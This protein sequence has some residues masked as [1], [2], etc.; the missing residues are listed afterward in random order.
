MPGTL[1]LD[2]EGLS[3]LYLKDRSVLALVQAA[4][5]EGIRVATSAM[6][7]L[8][9][10]YE[11]IHPA[12]ISWVLSRIDIH[13]VTRD[14]AAQAAALLRHHHLHGHKYAIDAVLAA[15]AHNAPG[16]VTVVTSDP[17]DLSQLCGPT[18]EIITA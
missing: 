10:D 13:D 1:L 8:E 6:T 14:L 7:T 5:E 2:S 12:R 17:E 3:K 4:T 9:A 18:A 16:P 11:R 15:I